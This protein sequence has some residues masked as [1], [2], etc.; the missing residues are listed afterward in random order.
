MTRHLTY[1]VLDDIELACANGRLDMDVLPSVPV[2]H[3]GPL[4]QLKRS[5]LGEQVL[6]ALTIEL[7]PLADAASF[8]DH[9]DGLYI[10]KDGSIGIAASRPGSDTC[11]DL[12]QRALVAIRRTALPLDS[13]A[14]AV[15]ALGELASNIEEHSEDREMGVIAF[16]VNGSFVGLY[17][18]DKGRGVLKSLRE[19]PTYR[20]LEDAGE[21]LGLV[22]QEGVSSSSQAGRGRGFRPLFVGLAGHAGLLRFRSG[23]ALLELNGFGEGKPM[24]ELKERAQAVGFHVFVHCTFRR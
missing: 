22:I 14:Q 7:G 12:M 9:P 15:S 4:I 2:R 8:V 10:S 19:N 20:N 23:G 16:E 3:L 5:T 1:G 17:A 24:Q 13:A 11:I 18:S 21:A 6:R